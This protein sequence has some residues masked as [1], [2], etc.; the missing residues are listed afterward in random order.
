MSEYQ[1]YEFRAVDRPLTSREMASLRAISSRAAITPASFCNTYNYGDFRGDPE[2]LMGQYFDAFVY[3]ANWGT[4]EFMLRLP[5]TLLALPGHAPFCTRSSLRGRIRGEHLVLSFR[6]EELDAD[7][8]EGEG[9]LDTLL[10]LR[11]D[12]LQGDLR[13]LYLGWLLGVQ[14]EEV[15]DDQ[16]EPPV[17]AGLRNLSETL[18]RL[19]EFLNIDQEL[20]EAASEGSA[21]SDAD[22]QSKDLL[23]RWITGLPEDEKDA[24]LL[25][26][27]A[28]ANSH[29]RADLLS[30]FRAAVP[31]APAQALKAPR[32]AA[33]L[34]EA[35]DTW[36]RE[37]ARREAER[38]EIERAEEE[39]RKAAER[40]RLLH[41]LERREEAA[42]ASLDDLISTKRPADY[43]SA[44]TLLVDLRDVA[45]R[46]GREGAFRL[47]L[48]G[49]FERHSGKSSLL[50]RAMAAGLEVR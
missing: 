28:G 20:I 37:K 24:I 14:N 6:A 17:P 33:Q 50:R 19:V 7:W 5:G 47:R 13:A 25:E 42:W 46:G 18:K 39:R 45:V 9:W 26:V 48:G 31:V 29:V 11:A 4:R 27:V 30:R 1:Y 44:V 16:P 12:L 49:V 43:D 15:D 40:A 38:R 22:S 21:D 34:R 3:V 41:V 32:T 35:A 8:E 23:A 2:T 10:P 36:G